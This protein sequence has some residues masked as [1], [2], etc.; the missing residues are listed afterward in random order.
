MALSLPLC[1][2]LFLKELSSILVPSSA[3]STS[4]VAIHYLS[5]ITMGCMG[6]LWEASS[7]GIKSEEEKSLEWCV[8][9]GGAV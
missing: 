8:V 2:L 3:I 1:D 7:H 9:C 4:S 5:L 6:I